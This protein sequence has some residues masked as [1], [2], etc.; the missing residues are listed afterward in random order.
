VGGCLDRQK[1]DKKVA[2]TIAETEMHR[3]FPSVSVRTEEGGKA[4]TAERWGG[5]R[6]HGWLKI[7]LDQRT[8]V[9]KNSGRGGKKCHIAQKEELP[10]RRYWVE[11]EESGW[12]R[13]GGLL[14]ISTGLKERGVHPSLFRG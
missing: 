7:G 11:G 3:D 1:R 10:K 8:G 14:L 4:I 9:V 5:R 12:D 2:T 6:Y 13:E